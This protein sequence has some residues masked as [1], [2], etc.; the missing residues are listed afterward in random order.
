MKAGAAV[1]LASIA[2]ALAACYVP[3]LGGPGVYDDAFGVMLNPRMFDTA[4]FVQ[5]LLHPMPPVPEG[6]PIASYGWRPLGEASFVLVGPDLPRQRAV[7]LMLHACSTLLVLGLLGRLLPPAPA[8]WGAAFFALHPMAVPAVT[9]AYQRF[10]SLEASLAL[11]CLWSYA[12]G[13]RR[14]ALLPGLLAMGVKETAAT[15]PLLI[16]AWEWVLRDPREPVRRPLRRWL[17]FACLPAIVLVQVLRANA[18]QHEATGQGIFADVTGFSSGDYLA[19]QMPVLLRYGSLAFLPFPLRFY[20]DRASYGAYGHL[21]APLRPALLCGTALAIL[22][23]FALFGP[24]RW[25]L[26]RLGIALFFAPLLLESSFVPTGHVGFLHRCY[27]G[28]TGAALIFAIAAPYCRPLALA[29]IGLLACATSAENRLWGRPPDLTRRDV[30][31]AFHDPTILGGYA[32]GY[33]RAGNPATA[34]R[35]FRHALSGSWHTAKLRASYIQTLL[36][37][38]HV[39]AAHERL[40]RSLDDFKKDPGL[41]WVAV[42]EARRLGDEERLSRMEARASEIDVATPELAVWLAERRPPDA[43][44]VLRRSLAYYPAHP[45][46]WAALGN[47]LIARDRLGDA[48]EAFARAVAL[49]PGY[50]EAR[51]N[52]GALR[53]ARRD[54]DGAEAEFREALRLRP[55]YAKAAENLE[56][57][58]RLRGQGK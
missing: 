19:L 20:W 31:H 47:A 27:P 50:A 23:A 52:L 35:L 17:P 22:A 10:V 38:G 5:G 8:R 7:N 46:L 4:G 36:K 57:V 49:S 3:S 33:L 29:T 21:D 55:G 25:R 45:L 42:E 26:T 48:E 30:R 37:L 34:E 11:L 24:R 32:S 6:I 12:R 53:L 56:W 51:L 54:L 39:E 13:R 15:L 41:L 58:R 16:G 9:Y 40:G 18:A 14:W 44:R 1:F 28:L 43:E 2:A